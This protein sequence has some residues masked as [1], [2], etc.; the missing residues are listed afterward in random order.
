[1]ARPDE[2]LSLLVAQLDTGEPLAAADALAQLEDHLRDID[3]AKDFLGSGGWRV[4]LPLAAAR[5]APAPARAARARS[6]SRCSTSSS[7][8]CG[9]VARTAAE[10]KLD[11]PRR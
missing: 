2:T 7:T 3:L 9:R 1:M 11:G 8:R 5:G 6:A 10:E 4:A